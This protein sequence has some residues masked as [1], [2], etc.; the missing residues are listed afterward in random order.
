MDREEVGRAAQAGKL[1]ELESRR[2]VLLHSCRRSALMQSH[3]IK[4]QIELAQLTGSGSLN[5]DHLANV[6]QQLD[7]CAAHLVFQV[8]A[9]HDFAR[10]QSGQFCRRD[11]LCAFCARLRAARLVRNYSERLQLVLERQRDGLK[12]V[13]VVFTVKNGPHLVERF[14][15]L[16]RY[17]DKLLQRRRNHQKGFR[18]ESG[19][20]H[21][22]GGVASCEI[23]RGSGSGE[24]HPHL[25][26]I[27]IVRDHVDAS[28]LAEQLRREWSEISNGE[29]INVHVDDVHAFHLGKSLTLDELRSSFVEVFKYATKGRDMNEAD[30]FDAWR[31]LAGRRLIR[32]F[33]WLYGVPEPERL[34]DQLDEVD[35]EL[36]DRVYQSEADGYVCLGEAPAVVRALEQQDQDRAMRRSSRLQ[37]FRAIVRNLVEARAAAPP[38]QRKSGSPPCRFVDH[39]TDTG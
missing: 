18:Q 28:E 8:N 27:W 1:S 35:F 37:D 12:P 21:A 11:R 20:S 26:C 32:A 31:L 33:G 9:K 38:G 36:I 16:M 10:L 23:K 19:A 22:L 39:V 34:G 24:W 14:E 13:H 30:S 3:F 25:H 7:Q 5:P 4:G 6:V 29:S 2:L 15:A 17:Y